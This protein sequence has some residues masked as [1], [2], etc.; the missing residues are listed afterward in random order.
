[1]SLRISS[2]NPWFAHT[3]CA[4]W[5]ATPSLQ[6]GRFSSSDKGNE[7]EPQWGIGV[8]STLQWVGKKPHLQSLCNFFFSWVLLAF[9]TEHEHAGTST[10][11]SITSSLHLAQK[12]SAGISPAIPEVTETDVMHSGWVHKQCTGDSWKVLTPHQTCDFTCEVSGEKLLG[13]G[14]IQ[15][16]FSSA[17][18]NKVDHLHWKRSSTNA[19]QSSCAFV[20]LCSRPQRAFCWSSS[21]HRNGHVAI[22]VK[23]GAHRRKLQGPLQ[24]NGHF[25]PDFQLITIK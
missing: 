4:L 14:E 9:D 5:C 16:S 13:N 21:S 17:R 19:L 20:R 1:M 3:L 8:A 22:W 12:P 6:N 15:P 10:K 18:L 25:L 24:G 23:K 2:I 11:S 7:E